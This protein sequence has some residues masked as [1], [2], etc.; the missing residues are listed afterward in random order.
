MLFQ[1]GQSGNPAGRKKGVPNK[2]TMRSREAIV[3]MLERNAEMLEG[4]A[5]EIYDQDGPSAA[6][7]VYLKFVEF[8]IPKLTRQTVAGDPEAPI[9]KNINVSFVDA[10]RFDDNDSDTSQV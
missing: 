4:W 6:M 9:E 3:G 2:I 5:R 8:H 10:V 1:K 7:D